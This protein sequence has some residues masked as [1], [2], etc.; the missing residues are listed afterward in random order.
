V[1]TFILQLSETHLAAKPGTN[2]Q[3]KNLEKM[4]IIKGLKTSI[5]SSH[6]PFLVASLGRGAHSTGTPKGVNTLT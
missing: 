4:L 5:F 3:S 1:S 2:Y 6:P